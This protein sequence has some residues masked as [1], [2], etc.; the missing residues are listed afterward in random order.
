MSASFSLT[1]DL[2][3]SEVVSGLALGVPGRPFD[4]VGRACFKAVEG[5]HG[6][7][8]VQFVAG[9]GALPDD[10]QH[11]QDCVLHR[12]PV[13]MDGA[14]VRGGGVQLGR[15]Y[16]YGQVQAEEKKG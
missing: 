3:D 16:H 1:C 10:A 11:V 6:V 12:G 4:T 15:Q 9:A 13:H 7:G 14:V 5:H 2:A 8:G